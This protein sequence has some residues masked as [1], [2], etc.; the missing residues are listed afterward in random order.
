MRSTFRADVGNWLVVPGSKEEKVVVSAPGGLT[1]DKPPSSRNQP[2]GKFMVNRPSGSLYVFHPL[3]AVGLE[4]VAAGVFVS[5][6]AE[7]LREA[8]G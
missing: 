8:E 7:V 1:L 6:G 4:A 5:I 3:E 2:D